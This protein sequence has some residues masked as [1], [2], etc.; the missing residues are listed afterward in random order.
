MIVGAA[1]QGA[2]NGIAMYLVARWLLGFG[3]PMCI[4]A[5][6]SLIGELGYPKERPVLTSLFNSSYFVGSI[7]A[8]G[9][10]F[11]TQ[12]IKSNWAWRIPSLLQAAPSFLQVSLIFFVPESPR[13]LISKDRRDEARAILIKYHAEGDANSPLVNAEIAQIEETIRIELEASKQSWGD[14]IRRLLIGSLL[15]LFTQWS[16]NTLISYYLDTILTQVGFT[17]PLVKG[18]LNVGLT[19]WNL[20]NATF[21]ALVVTR[22]K[23]RKMYLACTISLLVSYSSP[24]SSLLPRK[25]NIPKILSIQYARTTTLWK[26]Y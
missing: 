11:G 7:L 8:A 12:N 20:V 13:F 2:S 21:L 1:V 4:V 25:F 10:T 26:S 23:R 6:S 15:G 19:C 18:K 9:I 24:L 22:F 16:G 5:G 14:M 3:I 17:D